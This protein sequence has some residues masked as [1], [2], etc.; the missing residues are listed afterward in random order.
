MSLSPEKSKSLSK[1]DSKHMPKDTR[2]P[3]NLVSSLKNREYAPVLMN[4]PNS[5]SPPKTISAL[6]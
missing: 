3:R 5:L 4:K 1:M 6:A 2:E